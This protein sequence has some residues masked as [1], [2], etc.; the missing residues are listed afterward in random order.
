ML[1]PVLNS[2]YSKNSPSFSAFKMNELATKLKEVAKKDL[3]ILLTDVRT[4]K[5]DFMVKA[6]KSPES[7]SP[8][9]RWLEGVKPNGPNKISSFI[10]SLKNGV[11]TSHNIGKSIPLNRWA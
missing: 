8:N 7:R 4:G 9:H 3:G 11:C 5:T 2:V 1:N 6:L 10:I